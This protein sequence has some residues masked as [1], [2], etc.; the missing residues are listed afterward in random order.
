[1]NDYNLSDQQIIE[2]EL[3]HRTLRDKR[4]ADR[5][6]AV[7]AL[8]K[9]LSPKS[10]AEILLIDEKTS[11]NY[12]QAYLEK[13]AKGLLVMKYQGSSSK[14]SK[15]QVKELEQH[16]EKIVYLDAKSVIQHIKRNYKIVYSLSGVTHL[17]HRI[18]FSYKKPSPT[19]GKQNPIEQAD[20]IALYKELKTSKS[21]EDQIYFVDA[22]HPQHNSVPAYGWIKKG[23]EKQ[24]K[25][26]SGRQRVNIN[27]AFNIETFGSIVAFSETVNAQSTIALFKK[28][29]AKNPLSKTIYIVLDNARY[30]HSKLLKKFISNT[31]I[32]LL[33]VPSYSPNLNLIERYWKFFKKKVLYNKYYETFLEFT[34]ACKSFFRKRTKYVSELRTLITE[35]FHLSPVIK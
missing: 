10:I 3:L 11:R 34:N 17:L 20:F 35:N 29:L 9:G 27:G 12:F 30:Y 21:P 28:I 26:N 33:H 8:S 31:K 6:K 24:L 32:K 25:S 7:I 2:L 1:M 16:L 19:P 5:V 23:Q 14:L 15:R 4:Q 22:T 18:G 13:G